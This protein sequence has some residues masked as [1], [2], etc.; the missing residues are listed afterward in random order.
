MIEYGWQSSDLI[1]GMLSSYRYS[2]FQKQFLLKK[3]VLRKSIALK[4]TKKS[5][6]LKKCRVL[7]FCIWRESC[8]DCFLIALSQG[9]LTGGTC[10]SWGC[11]APK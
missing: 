10:T 1:T 9:F 5:K 4:K 2:F 3:I 6:F 8:F 7:D 11:K